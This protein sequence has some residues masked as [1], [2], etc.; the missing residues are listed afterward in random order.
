MMRKTYPV[1]VGC[2]IFFVLILYKIGFHSY[3]MYSLYKAEQQWT[4]FGREKGIVSKNLKN[5]GCE[6]PA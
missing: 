2:A 1:V 4:G 3:D 5:Q 6:K